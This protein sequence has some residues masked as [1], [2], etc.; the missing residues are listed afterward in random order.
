MGTLK[1][2]FFIMLA[3]LVSF[4]QNNKNYFGR[5][6]D[7]TIP[8]SARIAREEHNKMGPAYAKVLEVNLDSDAFNVLLNSIEKS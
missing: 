7:V 3:P 1:V 2:L 5:I 8:A 6:T 4:S